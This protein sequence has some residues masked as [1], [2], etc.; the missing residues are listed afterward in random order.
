MQKDYGPLQP[1]LADVARLAFTSQV[2]ER[3]LSRFLTVQ[4]FCLVFLE[5][6][7]IPVPGVPPV[8]LQLV[9]MLVSICYMGMKSQLR[10][11]VKRLVI[12]G[13]FAASTLVSQMLVR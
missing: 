7:A 4:L 2:D 3:R 11:S 13:L 5:K 10:L 1:G 9:V 8:S 12:W 6:I